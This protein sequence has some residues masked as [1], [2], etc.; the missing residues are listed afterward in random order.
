MQVVTNQ[1]L[2]EHRYN[3][4][5][6]DIGT[7]FPIVVAESCVKHYLPS[8]QSNEGLSKE[9]CAM[10]VARTVHKVDTPVQSNVYLQRCLI[11]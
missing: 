7:N 8:L 2:V 9:P 11:N 10:K 5:H 3:S 4:P 6:E 1:R